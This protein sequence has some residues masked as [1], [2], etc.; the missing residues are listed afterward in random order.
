MP[1]K[2][3]LALRDEAL[4]VA[5]PAS[6]ISAGLVLVLAAAA[7]IVEQVSIRATEASLA[8]L[9]LH[10][11]LRGAVEASN[12]GFRVWSTPDGPVRFVIT[13]SCTVIVL[14]VPMLLLGVALLIGKRSRPGHVL[15]AAAACAVGLV[16]V[17]QL[18]LGVIAAA[19]QWGGLSS[20][21]EI[22]HVFVGSV[23]SIVGFAASAILLI[24]IGTSRGRR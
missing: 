13:T 11:I 9:W 3:T 15:A 6:R 24:R 22:A 12:D 14:M 5:T 2:R 19:T 7:L 17:S 23:I 18:R 1:G 10:P 16:I 4:H 8:A 20:G 21:F